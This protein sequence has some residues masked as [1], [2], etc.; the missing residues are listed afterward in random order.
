MNIAVRGQF[1]VLPR[2][3]SPR[4]QTPLWPSKANKKRGAS[5]KLNYKTHLPLNTPP[6]PLPG[7]SGGP[8]KGR[9]LNTPR[10]QRK[11]EYLQRERMKLILQA[12]KAC[13]KLHMGEVPWSKTLQAAM[14]TITLWKVVLSRNKGTRVSTRYIR[15]LKKTF[16]IPMEIAFY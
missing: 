8:W 12:E 5:R 10:L 7:G 2:T 6:P 9:V 15:R 13:R 14:D 1:K 3:T 4:P 16:H 11:F